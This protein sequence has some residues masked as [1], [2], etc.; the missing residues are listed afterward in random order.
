[1]KKMFI[2]KLPHGGYRLNNKYINWKESMG[3][4]VKFIYDNIKGEVEIIDYY[5]KNNYPCLKI[6]YKNKI[7]PININ[8]FRNCSLGNIL[9][10]VNHNYK[11]QIGD[12]I[13]NVASGKLKILEQI[14]IKGNDGWSRKYYRYKCLICGNIDTISEGNLTINKN[15]CSVCSGRK[16]LKGYNDMWTTNSKLASLLADPEDGYKYT[17]S[18]NQYVNWECPNCSN[19][20][21]H[22]K[23]CQIKEQ[24]LSCPKC[25]DK[26][27]YPEKFVF[28][29][30]QQLLKNEFI[31]QLSKTNFNWCDTYLYDFYFKINNERYIM[32]THGLQHYQESFGKIKSNKYVRT[33]EEEQENDKLKKQIAI[34]NGIKEENY[35]IIDCSK[36]TLK[37]IKNNI[38]NSRLNDIFDLTKIDWLRCHKY[39]LNSLV[40]QACN[41]WNN[42]VY[43]TS[44]IGKIMKLTKNTIQ[45]YL[46]Q[47]TKLGWCNYNPKE[48]MK[49]NGYK[50]G[51]SICK[52]VINIDTKLQFNSIKEA[53]EYYNIN[54]TCIVNCCKDKYHIA[55]GYHWKYL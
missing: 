49:K 14:K 47:G 36:S 28:N 42:K 54:N 53:S 8:D 34:E 48:E 11:Y 2:E 31:Y 27:S 10:L 17:Q 1:M 30:L 39:A 16:V 45:K 26:L 41:L 35:I 44:E 5:M 46:K 43:T 3:Y 24:G 21:K 55:G 52:K 13:N 6:K 20:I 51:K 23:I 7:Y 40:K 4:K 22:K 9:G 12:V 25:G 19:I 32:E 18:A 37:F 33:L 15:G 50:N 29:I 38:L